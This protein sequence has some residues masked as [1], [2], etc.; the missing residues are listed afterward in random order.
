MTIEGHLSQVAST[1]QRNWDESPHIFMLA[2]RASTQETTGMKPANMVLVREISLPCDL[3]FASPPDKEQSRP[4]NHPNWSGGHMTCE[5]T[6]L[7]TT[8]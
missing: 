5:H 1:H 6:T 7:P 8:T 3:L 2:Y 4:N